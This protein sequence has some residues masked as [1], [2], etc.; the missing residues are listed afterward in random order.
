MDRR[1]FAKL[2]AAAVVGVRVAD[3]VLPAGPLLLED[4]RTNIMDGPGSDF[5]DATWPPSPITQEMLDDCIRTGGYL[6]H[7][8]FAEQLEAD[9]LPY[10][11]AYRRPGGARIAPARVR[12]A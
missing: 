5:N 2:I 7:E 8:D 1:R 6:V 9:L 4:A 11:N 12:H 3:E 10:G